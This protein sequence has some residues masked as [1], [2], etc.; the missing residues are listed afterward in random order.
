MRTQLSIANGSDSLSMA[1]KQ[2]RAIP[3]R[4]LLDLL[5]SLQ[6]QGWK[7]IVISDQV[8]FYFSNQ[9]RQIWLR[10]EEDPPANARPMIS[11][12]KTMVIVVWNPHEFHVVKILPR[13]CKWTSQYDIDHILSEI[14]SLHFAVDRRQLVVRVDNVRP[15][16]STRVK[17]YMENHSLRTHSIRHIP[18]I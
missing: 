10:E 8:W 12:S 11:S 3:S 13:G 6:Q 15:H 7:Y 1:E 16:V 18:R 9:H 2:M 4:N 5:D 14:S 17:E